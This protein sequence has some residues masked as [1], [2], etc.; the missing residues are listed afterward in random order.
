MDYRIKTPDWRKTE[1]ICLVNLLTLRLW[2]FFYT[3]QGHEDNCLQ[4]LNW[5]ELLF[6]MFTVWHGLFS[7]VL[8]FSGLRIEAPPLS[9]VQGKCIYT[10]LKRRTSKF[11]FC[12]YVLNIVKINII[13]WFLK[14]YSWGRF[15]GQPCLAC[16]ISLANLSANRATIV[17]LSGPI[18]WPNMPIRQKLLADL[19]PNCKQRVITL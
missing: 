6:S 2:S 10:F 7:L 17:E 4:T 9:T 11:N 14:G 19:S 16:T 12:S 3:L 15:I 18:Y 5:H 1:H 13:F 8:M